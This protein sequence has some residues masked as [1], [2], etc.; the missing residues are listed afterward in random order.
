MKYQSD[1]C[2]FACNPT[3]NIRI[4]RPA[5]GETDDLA[6]IN[7]PREF[8]ALGNTFPPPPGC[9][10]WVAAISAGPAII[11]LLVSRDINDG[12]EMKVKVDV[13]AVAIGERVAVLVGAA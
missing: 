6:R 10:W 4:R 7:F 11:R 9:E 1:H 5:A 8:D 3:K 2:W 12:H 13:Y